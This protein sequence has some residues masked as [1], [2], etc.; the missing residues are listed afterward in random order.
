MRPS[1]RLV[2]RGSTCSTDCRS[3]WV[4]RAAG[5]EHDATVGEVDPRD[6]SKNRYIVMH[7]RFDPAR[8]ERCNV[9]LAAFDNEA[10]FLAE[11]HRRALQL[12]HDKVLGIAEP[13]EHV[14]G[15]VKGP[16]SDERRFLDR[17]ERPRRAGPYVSGL[18]ETPAVADLPS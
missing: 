5:I 6:D 15:V 12:E 2:R 16:G 9:E 11:H 1:E 10:E 18:G 7:F 17:Q 13:Q 3:A 4:D 8:R 14:H